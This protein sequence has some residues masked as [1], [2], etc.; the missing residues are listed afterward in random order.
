[1]YRY[2]NMHEMSLNFK[3]LRVGPKDKQY[4]VPP[5]PFGSPASQAILYATLWLV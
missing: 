4:P 2:G 1:V 3:A 5:S